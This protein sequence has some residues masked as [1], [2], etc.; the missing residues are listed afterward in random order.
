MP[1]TRERRWRRRSRRRRRRR[2]KE[3]AGLLPACHHDGSWFDRYLFERI[4]RD[5]NR[6]VVLKARRSNATERVAMQL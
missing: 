2:R 6:R 4:G 3:E 5:T 1:R